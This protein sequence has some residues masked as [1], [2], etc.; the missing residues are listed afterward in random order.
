MDCKQTQNQLCDF[1]AQTC[2]DNTA[3]AVQQH[4]AQCPPC[5]A[6][7][8]ELQE[9]LLRL[10]T[11][12]QELPSSDQSRAMW[13]ACEK[14]IAAASLPASSRPAP[15]QP[16]PSL[17]L[18][19]RVQQALGLQ[20]RF[21][22]FALGGAFAALCGALLTSPSPTFAPA[23]NTAREYS[24]VVQRSVRDEAP[25][26]LVASNAQKPPRAAALFIDHH[27]A[28]SFDPFTDHVGPTLVSF[29]ASSP[30]ER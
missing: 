26:Q 18:M 15:A 28:M 27:T 4:L 21:G 29:S 7:W 3:R 24:Q 5:E 19:E 10:S 20:P 8:R 9:S 6:E 16:A 11:A 17:S 14:K 23:G 1:S 12:T 2:D 13:A 25:A 22:W 30:S